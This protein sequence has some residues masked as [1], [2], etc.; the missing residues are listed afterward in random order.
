MAKKIKTHEPYTQFK[1][2][3]RGNSKKYKDVSEL[4]HCTI[5]TVSQKINGYSDFSISEVNK[6]INTY[7]ID[8]NIFLPQGCENT[9]NSNLKEVS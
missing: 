5:G 6:I 2:W 3:L 8:Y 4:L 9:T 1:G 7:G